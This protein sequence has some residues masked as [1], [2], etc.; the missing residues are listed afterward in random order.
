MAKND[1]KKIIIFDMDGVL[2]DTI[3]YARQAFLETHPG[4]T[5]DIYNEIHSGNFYKEASKYSHLRIKETEEQ[6]KK[7]NL[8]Y[9]DK[10]SKSRIFDGI[11]KLLTQLKDEEFILVLNTNAY[12]RN[13]FPLLEN[14][15]ISTFFDFIASA[16][17]SKDK[18]EKFE[19]IVKKYNAEKE[20]TLFITD[21]LGDVRDADIAGVPTVAVTWGVHDSPFFKREKHSNLL[22]IVDSV[23]DLNKAIKKYFQD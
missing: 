12:D 4:V 16:E 15:G 20:N 5:A 18:I 23:E 8:D 6:R 2:F 17:L 7:R 10:K 11:K 1:Q 3:P 19:L 22:D 21:A 14:G 9:A 13:S